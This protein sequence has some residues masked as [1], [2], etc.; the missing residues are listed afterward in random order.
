MRTV[1]L[2]LISDGRKYSSDS[3]VRLGCD[4][5]KGLSRCCHE[6]CDTIILD[7]YDVFNMCKGLDI[8]FEDLLKGTVELGIHDGI[9]LPNIRK[10][11]EN[12][13]CGYLDDSGRCNIHDF[14]PGFC[15][16][17]PLGRIYENEKL[18]YVNQTGECDCIS[19][20]KT[21]VK[22]WMGI[23][24]MNTYEEFNLSWHAYLKDVEKLILSGLEESEIKSVNMKLLNTFYILPYDYLA[25]FYPQFYE[26]LKSIQN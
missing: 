12:D 4:G 6:M 11:P 20:V 1:D 5:C 2:D 22:K 8:T 10:R 9:I 25:D 13:G 3:M 18:S 24:N 15:R 19:T 17:F 21:K 26:R 7:P 23:S 16:L 14:R